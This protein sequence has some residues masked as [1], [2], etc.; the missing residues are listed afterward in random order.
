MARF[1]PS[2]L[3]FAGV[4]PMPAKGRGGLKTRWTTGGSNN[5]NNNNSCNNNNNNTATTSAA[6]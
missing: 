1:K 4:V 2:N 5:N 3:L 6:E